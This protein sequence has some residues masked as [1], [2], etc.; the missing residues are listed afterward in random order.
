MEIVHI[1][2]EL[3]PIAKV[4]GLGDVL[5]GLCR[6]L[7]KKNH[8]VTVV[9][10]KYDT[11]DLDQVKHLEVVELLP[12][13]FDGT[14]YRNTFWKGSVDGIPVILIESHHPL[15]FFERG[16]IYACEDDTARFCYFCV[17]ALSYVQRKVYDV[18]HIHDWHTGL[19]AGLM[20]ERYPEIEAKVVFTIHN[21]TYQGLCRMEDLD[22]VDWKSSLIKESGVYSL[23]KAGIVFADHVT[24]VSP[25]YAHEILTSELGGNLQP[26]LQQHFKKFCG[27]LNGIDY[28]YWDPQNDSYLPFS[29]SAE[30]VS[31]KW[32]IKQELRRRLSLTDENCPLVGTVTRLVAQKGPE[33]L[34][35]SLLRTLEWGG[36]FILL[37]SALDERTHTQFYN[38]K[39]TLEGSAHVHLEL[40]YNEELSHLFFAAADLFLIPSLFEPCGLTQMIAMRYGTVPLVRKTGGLADT[41]FEE[42]NG[43]LF[44]HPT[45]EAIHSALDRALGTWYHKPHLWKQLVRTGMTSDFSWD[46]PAEKYL[47]IYGL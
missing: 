3:A 22:K 9:L 5:H 45:I 24:T 4:G 2:A 37:G 7:L 43:F 33:F 14:V 46:H 6:S 34:K 18:V 28:T 23:L 35:A 11:L 47:R 8:A 12:V 16:K 19:I 36:Q 25:T 32:K 40:D 13:S 41:V 27:V 38:L 15:N 31:N 26:T 1:A 39:R 44:N 17:A 29:Y 42:K 30:D 20:K 21:L 10:P